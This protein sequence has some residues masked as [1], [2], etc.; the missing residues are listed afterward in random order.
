MSKGITRSSFRNITLMMTVGLLLSAM[1]V[2][3]WASQAGQDIENRMFELANLQQELQNAARLS[4]A[5]SDLD[6]LTIDEQTATRLNILRHLGLEQT[7]YNFNISSK[8]IRTVGDSNLFLRDVVLTA[9]LPYSAALALADRLHN[10]KKIVINSLQLRPSSLPG[11]N[12]EIVL[13]G[14]IYGLEKQKEDPAQ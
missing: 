1:L 3:R 13:S 6:Q 5:L 9:S 11:D 10:T 14:T 8:Q 4:A 12:V 7:N 2:F